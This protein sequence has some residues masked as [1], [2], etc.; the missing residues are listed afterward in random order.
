MDTWTA[1]RTFARVLKNQLRA[2]IH[3]AV[4]VSTGEADE[5]AAQSLRGFC[6][7]LL[8][9]EDCNRRLAFPNLAQVAQGNAEGDGAGLRGGLK[10][11]EEIR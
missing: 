9:P 3:S 8:F 2:A 10:D 5:I 7:E 6:G 11:A 1:E 4:R